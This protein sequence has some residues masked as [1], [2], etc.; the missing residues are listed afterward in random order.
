M[1]GT[2]MANLSNSEH[3]IQDEFQIRT[4]N[5]GDENIILETFNH[6]FKTQ[7][8]MEHWKWKYLNN[9]YG[10]TWISTI[11]Y[12]DKVVAQYAGYPVY[13]YVQG[14][15]QLSCQAA[16]AFTVSSYRK[17]GHGATSLMS[18]AFHHYEQMFC[19][20]QTA[21][22]YGF[23]VNKIQRLGKM[24][25]QHTVPAP[26][27]QRTLGEFQISQYRKI[28]T[29]FSRL[30]GYNV[31]KTTQANE[32]ADQVFEKVKDDYGWLLIREQKY[33]KWRYEQH[34]DFKHDFFVVYFW[35]KP[36]GWIV[37][38]LDN[39]RWLLGDALFEPKYAYIALQLALNKLFNEYPQ[40][41]QIDSW[42]SEVPLWWNE[43][44]DKLGFIK[45]RQFQNLDLVVRFYLSKIT[46][47]ELAQKF[48]FT[49]G[50]SDLY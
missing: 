35:G 50:D 32:W 4:Y 25:W 14:K 49:W 2:P 36:V 6:V 7:R 29:W 10:Q 15:K 1:D 24:F 26:V 31:I 17:V 18:R 48:Y 13:L 33:L 39:Q 37:G 30:K 44:L 8:T 20:T 9:P 3:E 16:D 38:R 21:F 47:E 43:L 41:Q 27:Y 5:S 19:E 40:I 45:Q 22:G 28:R 42:C 46:P 11:W 34:P 23:N 12:Q